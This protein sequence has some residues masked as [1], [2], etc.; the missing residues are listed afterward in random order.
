MH[1]KLYGLVRTTMT[2]TTP[3]DLKHEKEVNLEC[4]NKM[5]IAKKK[6]ILDYQRQR[7]KKREYIRQHV[8]A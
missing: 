2:S 5:A 3:R 1:K 4:C 8:T 7:E 6:W